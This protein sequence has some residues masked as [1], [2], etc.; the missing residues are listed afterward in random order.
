MFA[1]GP[2]LNVVGSIADF[3]MLYDIGL[4]IQ[5]HSVGTQI[6]KSLDKEDLYF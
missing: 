1:E 2:V 5:P 4:P 6:I 3:C